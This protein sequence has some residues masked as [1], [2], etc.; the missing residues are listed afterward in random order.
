MLPKH[1]IDNVLDQLFFHDREIPKHQP[2]ILFLSGSLRERSC[3]EDSRT[4]STFG[5]E[6]RFFNSVNL[7]LADISLTKTTDFEKLPES[8]KELRYMVGWCEAMVWVSPEVHGN[9]SSMYQKNY[10]MK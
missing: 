3:S 10:R 7:S 8:V 4:I 6:A 1:N 2:M 9:I 5:A